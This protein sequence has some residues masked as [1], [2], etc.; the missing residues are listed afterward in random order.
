MFEIENLAI[1]GVRLLHMRP[2]TDERGS[3]V[4]T[5]HRETF[6]EHGLPWNF[7]EQF[8][9]V[10]KKDVVRGM[11]LQTPPHGHDKLVYCPAGAVLD[12][13]V[14][15]RK[16]SPKFGQCL[17]VELTPENGKSLFIPKGIGHGFLS[18]KDNSVV[19][20]AVTTMHAPSSDTG[21]CW[22]SIPFDWGVKNPIVSKRDQNL[23]KLS[24]FQT[25][26]LWSEK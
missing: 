26:F 11:H 22:N 13:L 16:G 17:S 15:L 5:V 2:P 19:S 25:P 4:K 24:D 23:P 7:A 14:D 18:L 10:S 20:Y 8:Y 21:V 3:F 6:E 1:P 12:V 9:N